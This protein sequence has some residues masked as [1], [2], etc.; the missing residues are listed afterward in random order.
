K[1]TDRVSRADL[2]DHFVIASLNA[3]RVE[4]FARRQG[5]PVTH[6]VYEASRQ[7]IAAAAALFRRLGLAG[8][9]TADQVTDWQGLD[10]FDEHNSHLSFL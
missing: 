8:R 1:W 3:R 9:F 5:V 10:A 7:P 2:L 6:Y 4:A